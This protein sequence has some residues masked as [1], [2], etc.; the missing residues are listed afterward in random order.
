MKKVNKLFW[1]VLLIVLGTIIALNRLEITNINIFFDGWWTMFLII[2]SVLGIFVTKRISDNLFGIVV[3]TV[4]LLC[5]QDVIEYELLA[6][7]AVPFVLIYIGLKIITNEVF[8]SK[9]KELTEKAMSNNS[10]EVVAILKEN[11]K[12][13]DGKFDGAVIDAV[14]GHA[15]VD[16]CDAKIDDYAT[17]KA[18]AIFGSID[19]VVPQDVTIR[20]S[21]TSI[22]GTVNK[23]YKDKKIKDSKVIYIDAFTMF[24]GVTIK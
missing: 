4:L 5:A 21:S 6:K 22:F 17:V 16:L 7:L 9:S 18:S 3:G 8:S 13:F 23:K 2:P 1:G 11:N 20:L 19:I 12:K 24:G 14:L 15:K 10:E